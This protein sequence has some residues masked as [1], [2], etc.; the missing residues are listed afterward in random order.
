MFIRLTMADPEG[1][2]EGKT[3][4]LN[5]NQVQ[6]MQPVGDECRQNQLSEKTRLAM[7]GDGFIDVFETIPQILDMMQTEAYKLRYE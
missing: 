7:C 3:V 2:H 5:M 1:E 4:Y 6:T